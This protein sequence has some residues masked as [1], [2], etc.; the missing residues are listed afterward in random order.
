VLDMALSG[1]GN[2]GSLTGPWHNEE[3]GQLLRFHDDGTVI[4]RTPYGD[5][6]ATWV[7]DK[8]KKQ[9]VISLN[10]EA[11]GFALDGDTLTLTWG[12]TQT[13]FVPGDMEVV[14][15]VA[16]ATPMSTPASTPALTETPAPTAT[17]ATTPS[18]SSSGPIWSLG[19]FPDLSFVPIATPT[20]G[21]SLNP[22]TSLQIVIPGDI[23]GTL[24]NPLAGNWYYTE[25][26]SYVLTF[27]GDNGFTVVQGSNGFSGT[28]TYDTASHTGVLTIYIGYTS[29]EID[30]SVDGDVMVWEDGT[31]FIRE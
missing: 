18:A 30:F 11:I 31:T 2:A 25:D 20:P 24:A 8:D 28:Y 10:G 26:D 27:D 1:C 19:A 4:V 21:L 22:G 17:P 12:G 16:E 29:S 15:A 23:I 13:V 5:T 3:F 14:A 6:E 7:Y 9:G